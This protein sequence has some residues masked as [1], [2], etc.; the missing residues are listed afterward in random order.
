M[1]AYFDDFDINSLA[2]LDFSCGVF[3]SSSI[4][5]GRIHEIDAIE[6]Q[7][8]KGYGSDCGRRKAV[9]FCNVVVT[10]T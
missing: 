3:V 8:S 4:E 9:T 7:K 2:P 1:R 10:R 5:S 6:M